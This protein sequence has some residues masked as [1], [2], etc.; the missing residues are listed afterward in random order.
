MRVSN[1]SFDR[2]KQRAGVLSR[3][4]RNILIVTRFPE[5]HVVLIFNIIA[6]S[7]CRSLL[8][9]MWCPRAADFLQST[10]HW[11]SRQPEEKKGQ[12]CALRDVNR[13]LI[14]NIDRYDA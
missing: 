5:H 2:V 3:M 1:E 14:A 11:L 7:A 4:L 10:P 6:A 12:Y 9:K 13:V 8:P